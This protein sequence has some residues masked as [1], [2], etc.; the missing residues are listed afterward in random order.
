M[1]KS[2]FLFYG[3]GQGN[4]FKLWNINLMYN[5]HTISK[6]IIYRYIRNYLRKRFLFYNN[7]NLDIHI[8]KN[9]SYL[10]FL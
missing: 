3:H 7:E 5:V 10:K 2:N 4:K 9:K 1:I 6:V 8:F